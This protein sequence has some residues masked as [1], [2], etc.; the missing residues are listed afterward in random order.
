MARVKRSIVRI[1]EE[2]CDGCGACIPACAEGALQIVDGKA[3]LVSERYCDGLGACLGECPRGAISIEER[4]ADEF[5]SGPPE[6]HAKETPA[7]AATQPQDHEAA[8]EAEEPATRGLPHFPV[9][10]GLVRPDASF[11]REAELV[12][13]ADCTAFAYPDFQQRFLTGRSLLVACPKLDNL[14]AHLEKMVQIIDQ[15]TP[16]SITV[17]RMEVPCCAGLVRLAEEA[18]R[19]SGKQ[20]PLHSVTIAVGGEVLTGPAA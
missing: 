5:S 16:T 14:Q 2:K 6:A 4:V 8:G 7:G 17:V 20:V 13:A 18:V 10:L 15:S 11:L 12:L 9:Q 19:R 3:R 1:D